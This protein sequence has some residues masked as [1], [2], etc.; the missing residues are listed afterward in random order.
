[1]VLRRLK[2]RVGELNPSLYAY[3][4]GMST[5]QCINNILATINDRSAVILFLDLE[6]AFELA[7]PAAFLEVLVDNGVK[8]HMLHWTK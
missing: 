5:T 2:C 6:K 3:R 4:E 1:M 7:N 8:A